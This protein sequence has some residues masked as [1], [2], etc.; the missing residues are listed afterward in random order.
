MRLP[1][2]SFLVRIWKLIRGPLQWYLL[3][4]MHDK[5]IIGV[6][7]VVLDRENQI[8]LL[9]HQYWKEGSWGL[10]SGYAKKTERLEDAFAREVFEETGY[11]IKTEFLLR[12]KSGYRLRLEVSYLGYLVGGNLQLDGREVLEARFFPMDELPK[13]LLQSH[14]EII[15]AV[16]SRES[17]YELLKHIRPREK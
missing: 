17:S 10:P 16:I 12:I 15:D 1:T 13:G 6:S 11:I 5:F 9:R 8:L 7:G 4:L 14:R 3:W 2:T